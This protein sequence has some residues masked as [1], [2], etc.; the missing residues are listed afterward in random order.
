MKNSN[1]KEKQQEWQ[2]ECGEK[3]TPNGEH[4][5]PQNKPPTNE[6][7]KCNC[8]C[9]IDINFWHSKKMC[10]QEANKKA[11]LQDWEKEF[12]EEMSLLMTSTRIEPRELN[13]YRVKSFISKTLNSQKQKMRE[14][15]DL[16]IVEEILICRKENTPTSRL[17]SLAMKIKE[18]K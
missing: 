7:G 12:E 2:C 18:L 9:H 8:K 13:E 14:E 15:L 10:C 1:K 3:V 5:C 17:T 16:L 11:I 4:I 6:L